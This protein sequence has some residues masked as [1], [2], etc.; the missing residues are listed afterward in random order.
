MGATAIYTDADEFRKV[1]ATNSTTAAYAAQADATAEPAESTPGVID[2]GRGRAGVP[3]AVLFKFFGTD[4]DNETGGCR[5]Y[6]LKKVRDVAGGLTSYTHILLADVTFTLSART[7]VASGVVGASEFYADTIAR[8][9]GVENV[10]DQILSPTGDVPAHLLVDAKGCRWLKVELITGGS[11]ASV[12]ALHA[13][14]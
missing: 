13:G 7:G 9:T 10:S 6:G 4:A 2:L 1:L 8:V 12:N 11:A 14:V 3:N 5:V